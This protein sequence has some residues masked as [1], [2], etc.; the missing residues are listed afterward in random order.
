M[1]HFNLKIDPKD[2]F[3][4][5]KTSRKYFA[6]P[7]Y[8]VSNLVQNEISPTFNQP[9]FRAEISN[10]HETFKIYKTQKI[11]SCYDKN[12]TSKA[13]LRHLLGFKVGTD[14]KN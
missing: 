5:G 7:S 9:H 1:F 14:E 13:F 8:G 4:L 11:L 12:N 6:A 3:K 2:Y 10:N